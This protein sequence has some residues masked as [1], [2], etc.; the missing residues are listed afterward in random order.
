MATCSSR[1]RPPETRSGLTLWSADAPGGGVVRPSDGAGE[2]RPGLF[3]AQ[4]GP[5][6]DRAII[7]V[8]GAPDRSA[9]FRDVL[10][11]LGDHHVVVYDRRGYGRSLRAAPARGM[12]DHAQDLLS[13]VESCPTPPVVVAHSFGSN[14][15][16]LAATLRPG[17]LCRARPV[18][19]AAALG[20]VVVRDDE[21]LQRPDRAL[22]RTRRRHRGDVPPL[23]RHRRLGPIVRRGARPAP[24][25]GPGLPDGH[26]LR[27]RRPVRLPRRGGAR[28]HRLRDRDVPRARA[29]RPVARRAPARTPA[30][31]WS[32]A[33]GTS[34][35]A[36]IPGPSRTSSC[37]PRRCRAPP[38]GPRR[39]FCG[40]TPTG[41]AR[42]G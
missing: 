5:A 41:S 3:V 11:C 15:T 16:M 35:L 10:A 28:P 26:G 18:G 36:R 23:A 8:H 6:T 34:P 24:R 38:E 12:H 39:P 30:A 1:S 21:G 42:S 17:R 20:R 32:R 25:R 37:R 40:L 22:G 19:T 31:S 2:E 14:P 29:R 7:L 4:H 33:P 9:T 13:L 27:D